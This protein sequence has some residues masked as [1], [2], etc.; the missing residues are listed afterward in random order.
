M[1]RSPVVVPATALIALMLLAV[2][3]P[4]VRAADENARSAGSDGVTTVV[5]L[6]RHAEKVGPPYENSP[7]DPALTPGGK[8]RAEQL[9][10]VLADAGVTRIF[11]TDYRRTTETVEPLS[12]RLGLEVE[13]YDPRALAE[14]ARLLRSMSGRVV[15]SGHS[16]TTPA[17][18]SLL[19]G[20]SGEPI[21][22]KT[23]FDRLYVVT[24]LP[25]GPATTI[26]LRYGGRP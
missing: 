23:E 16:N 7:P 25:D 17:L 2:L 10:H 15:V 13:S 9:V 14:F 21:D 11:S 4:A 20:E 3:A 1:T 26:L 24:L 5:Y 18:V 19:G 6:L 8:Q 12:R 22:E